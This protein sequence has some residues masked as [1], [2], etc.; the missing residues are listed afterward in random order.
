MI[1]S[2]EKIGHHRPLLL[3]ACVYIGLDNFNYSAA[4]MLECY[5]RALFAPL[6]QS[7]REFLVVVVVSDNELSCESPWESSLM[8]ADAC[9]HR[10]NTFIICLGREMSNTRRGAH[11]VIVID[12]YVFVCASARAR[13]ADS[14]PRCIWYNVHATLDVCIVRTRKR[15]LRKISACAPYVAYAIYLICFV[16]KGGKASC[17]YD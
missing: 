2:W 16:C 13:V 14:D 7:R 8:K 12:D 10:E 9:S 1:W 4:E 17:V 11:T 5:T 6:K 15:C 3:L